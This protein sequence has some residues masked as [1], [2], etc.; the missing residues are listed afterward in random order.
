MT[1]YTMTVHEGLAELKTLASRIEKE[2]SSNQFVC[3]N[4]HANTKI[5]GVS[6]SDF[7]TKMK[8]NLQ[9]VEDLIKRRNA[10]KRAI[11]KSNAVTEVTL[12][13]DN[14]DTV[15]MTVAE[16][17][18]Y[19]NVGIQ[20]LERL[21]NTLSQQYNA[22][23]REITLRNNNL[24]EKADAYVASLFG[25]KEGISA[26][27]ITSARQSYVEANTLD[28]VDPNGIVDKINTLREDLD[29]YNTKVDAAL[30]TSNAVTVIEFEC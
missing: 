15:T 19:K 11:T 16:V 26:D 9:K 29:F 1:K 7:A 27:V 21:L 30:S 20:Y 25:S 17:I 10:I 5:D 2:L 12:R 6:V 22:A 3:N 8:S 13:K 4:K 18:E 24:D 28:L 14:G 23:T